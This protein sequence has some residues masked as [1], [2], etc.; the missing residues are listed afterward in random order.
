MAVSGAV[1]LCPFALYDLWQGGYVLGAANISVVLTL[2]IDAFAIFRRKEPPIPFPVLL[3]PMIAAIGLSLAT[4]GIYGAMWTYPAVL[5]FYFV[6]PR[7]LANIGGGALLVAASIFVYHF[8]DQSVAIRFVMS[9]GLTIAVINIVIN[10]I[11]RLQQDLLDIAI[12]DPLT[13]AYNR[14][15]MTETLNAAIDGDGFETPAGSVLLIDIDHFKKINDQHGHAAGDTVLK[16]MVRLIKDGA[17]PIDRLFR[18]GG[19]EFLLFLPGTKA[20]GAMV[21]AERLRKS[22]ADAHLLENAAVTVSVGLSA[23]QPN[24]SQ[25]VW[26]KR[27]DDALYRAKQSGRNRVVCADSVTIPEITTLPLR[28]EAGLGRRQRQR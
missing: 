27:G 20:E 2:A 8:F 28:D 24:Q 7:Q 13:G 3:I 23:Y 5:F 17:R 10:V 18:M 22:V 16:N 1:A 21:E 14:R 9:L 19:E 6:L 4:Q 25:D 12:T 11:T 15:H 26:I